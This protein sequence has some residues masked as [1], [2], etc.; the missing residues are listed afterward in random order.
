MQDPHPLVNRISQIS[1]KSRLGIFEYNIKNNV[2]TIA[3]SVFRKIYDLPL[4]EYPVVRLEDV[5]KRHIDPVH[6]DYDNKILEATTHWLMGISD[7]SDEGYR[8]Y[9]RNGDR[10][11]VN[12]VASY[13]CD[14]NGTN[15]TIIGSVYD[16]TH[17]HNLN[18]A[19]RMVALR[20]SMT[21]L[22]T[23]KGFYEYLSELDSTEGWLYQMDLDYFKAIN[24]VYGHDAGDVVISDVG[25][26][27][28]K[29]ATIQGG[30]AVRM[31]GEEFVMFIPENSVRTNDMVNAELEA[32][33]IAE[34]I[35]ND[36]RNY[37]FILPNKQIL[38][39]RTIS[40]GIAY[41]DK[42]KNIDDV[43]SLSDKALTYS[44]HTGRNRYTVANNDFLSILYHRGGDINIEDIKRAILEDEIYYVAQ[45]IVNVKADPKIIGFEL[46]MRW[47]LEDR[48][49]SPEYYAERVESVAREN[50]RYMIKLEQARLKIIRRIKALWPEA[51]IS[52][53]ATIDKFAVKGAGKEFLNHLLST[54]G[55]MSAYDIVLEITETA[56]VNRYSKKTIYEEL[57]YI[58]DAGIRIALDDFGKDSSNLTRLSELPVDII[59]L[60]KSFVDTIDILNVNS[61]GLRTAG[62][63]RL[64]A[65][66]LG[67]T[68]I[69]EGISNSSI[70]MA[71]K[72]LHIY[73]HQGYHWGKPSSIK[74]LA[75]LTDID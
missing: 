50:E 4:D 23:R 46:L 62:S 1:E 25:N 6:N 56:G 40:I 60:D 42:D 17:E 3:N 15:C 9:H 5:V 75:Y 2:F 70:A 35:L 31:G 59:K 13:E 26:I 27:L 52:L 32:E 48:E 68:I 57:S 18:Q 43:I 64:L 10:L 65:E 71:M 14:A 7:S 41:H 28:F 73:N 55:K 67:I 38:E 58:R 11:N 54:L 51:Y 20:D 19:L 47:D 24:D 33:S 12:R 39:D 44:K 30:V 21:G 29:I 8:V 34:Q 61:V 66:K 72:T 74:D 16:V 36:V 69:A 45:P 63:I 37:K 49:L 22:Y 53:N